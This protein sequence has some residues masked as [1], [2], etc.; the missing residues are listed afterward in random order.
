M[1]KY[2]VNI[3]GLYCGWFMFVQLKIVLYFRMFLRFWKSN[4]RL[5][6]VL[7]LWQNLFTCVGILR[8]RS[9]LRLFA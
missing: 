5:W 2:Y 6:V 9:V 4:L 7:R 3:A 1:A 8:V